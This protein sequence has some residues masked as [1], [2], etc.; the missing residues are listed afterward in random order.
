MKI[1]F[2]SLKDIFQKTE[3]DAS[4]KMLEMY[5]TQ[6]LSEVFLKRAYKIRQSFFKTKKQF[7]YINFSWSNRWT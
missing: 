7:F 4:G 3:R 1:Y 6:K 5:K 2:Y